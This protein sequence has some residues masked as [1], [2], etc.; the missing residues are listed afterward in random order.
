MNPPRIIVN[1]RKEKHPRPV[2]LGERVY[3]LFYSPKLPIDN[4]PHPFIPSLINRLLT[5]KC[6]KRSYNKR[7]SL[8]CS[9][10]S[11]TFRPFSSLVLFLACFLPSM[12]FWLWEPALGLSTNIHTRTRTRTR[13]LSNPQHMQNDTKRYECKKE[14]LCMVFFLVFSETEWLVR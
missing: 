8:G 1:A 12:T 9:F 2:N 10:P 4:A 7:S 11:L 14:G 3:T 6:E 5:E 13:T